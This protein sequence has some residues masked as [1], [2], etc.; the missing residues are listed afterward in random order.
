[1]VTLIRGGSRSGWCRTTTSLPPASG[2]LVPWPAVTDRARDPQ[3]PA[4]GCSTRAKQR[5]AFEGWA[6]RAGERTRHRSARVACNAKA[7]RERGAANGS[8]VLM[9]AAQGPWTKPFPPGWLDPTQ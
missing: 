4:S 3:R 2:P 8:E 9:A 7:T 5:G 1:M 6:W